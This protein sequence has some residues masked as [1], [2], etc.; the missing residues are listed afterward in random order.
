MR[1]SS[2]DCAMSKRESYSL[3]SLYNRNTYT[4]AVAVIPYEEPLIPMAV[5]TTHWKIAVGDR[6][7]LNHEGWDSDRDSRMPVGDSRLCLFL[8]GICL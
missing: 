3:H 6:D 2:I 8:G 4:Y 1:T 5:W 7:P